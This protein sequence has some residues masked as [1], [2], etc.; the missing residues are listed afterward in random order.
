[1]TGPRLDTQ[2]QGSRVDM[3][4]TWTQVTQ[5]SQLAYD[6]DEGYYSH[7]IDIQTEAWKGA[8]P[9]S[10][11]VLLATPSRAGFWKKVG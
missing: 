2:R 6:I 11:S 3:G 8:Q 1:M 9:S 4:I 10:Q 7:F 5:T